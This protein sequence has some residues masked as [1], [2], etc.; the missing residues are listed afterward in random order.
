MRID[1]REVTFRPGVDL[2]T[3]CIEAGVMVPHFCWH[4]AL[5]SVG[6]CRLCAVTVTENGRDRIEM[7]CMTPATD[8][9]EIKL[10]DPESEDFRA[11]VIEWLMVNHPHDCA[12]CEAGGACHLQ[13]MTVATGHHARR[14]RFPKRTHR[15][16]DLGPLLTHEMNRC[17]AC[18]RC[19]RFYRGYAGGRDLDVFGAHDNVYFGR[20]EDGVLESPFAGNLAEVCPTGVFNDKGWSKGYARPWD[21][22]HSPSVCNGC[23]VGCNLTISERHGRIRRVENRYHGAING[24]FL[25][26][27]GRFGPLWVESDARLATPLIRGAEVTPNAALAAAREVIAQGAIGIASPRASL[28]ANYALR[29]LVGA[30]RFF[31]GVPDAEAAQDAAIVAALASHPIA[32]LKDIETA[33]AALVLGEDLTGHAPRAAL[34]L[35]Q[36][37]RAAERALAAEKG[38]PHWLDNAVRVAGEGRRAAVTLVTPLADALD[39]VAA[40]ALRRDA[41]AVA[42]FGRAVA[43]ALRGE[44]A[45]D[46]ARAVAAEL[47]AAEA[48]VVIAGA[49]LGVAGTVEAAAEVVAALPKARLALFPAEANSLGLA[50]MGVAGGLEAAAQARGARPVIALETDLEG[51]PLAAA[52][53][54]ALEALATATTAGAQVALPVASFAEA[55]GTFVNHEGRAQRA[56]AARPDGPPAAWRVLSALG[57]LW[58]A[59]ARVDDVLARLAE[60]LP[61]LAGA[62]EAAPGSGTKPCAARAPRR[63]SGRTADDLAGRVPEGM[64][65][66]DPD[67]GLSWSMEGAQ[68]AAV[69]PARS[70]GPAEDGLH[71]PSAACL[72]QAY[73]GG[74]LKGGDPGVRVIRPG[75]ELARTPDAPAHPAE[76]LRVIP[77]HDPFAAHPSDRAG[78]P[79]AE[80]AGRP[81]M[82]LH[83]EDAAALGLSEGALATVAG[84]RLPVVCDAGLPRGHVGLPAALSRRVP[85]RIDAAHITPEDVQ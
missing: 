24:F 48:P 55:A 64:P 51:T 63:Y 19:T 20:A 45:Q 25:C 5:G 47:A 29:R 83:P 56:F 53:V 22:M 18:Y 62:A 11:R 71:S 39:G 34:A 12:V 60:D 79:L 31:A 69:D 10:R 3:A 61:V 73:V 44:A 80:R 21:M 35:R 68:G 13:D 76:G 9:M 50:L 74:P 40:R 6:A 54:V 7:S 26:D 30:E 77:L 65:P 17:I 70:S 78:A 57:G 43:A 58:D 66:V 36:T 14:A 49:G 67:G 59:D 42:A 52:Q 8:G 28:E 82:R 23:S 41:D 1:G 75:M 2:L 33:D 15:N 38:V 72:A 81:V 37:T 46:D 84:A 27:R 16:Q 32:S 85:A 4:G